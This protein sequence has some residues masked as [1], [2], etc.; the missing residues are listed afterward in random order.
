MELEQS[1]GLSLQEAV[2]K[3]V[4]YSPLEE[5]IWWIEVSQA[6]RLKELE[7]ENPSMHKTL[8]FESNLI[9]ISK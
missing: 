3:V 7:K 5:R 4:N 9:K 2:H 8:L 6:R 1:K